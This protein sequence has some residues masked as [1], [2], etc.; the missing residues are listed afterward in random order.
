MRASHL[1]GYYPS[2][3]IDS[4]GQVALLSLLGGRSSGGAI[5]GLIAIYYVKSL[6]FSLLFSPYL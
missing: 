6:I 1:L 2:D 4:K 3:R 5:P